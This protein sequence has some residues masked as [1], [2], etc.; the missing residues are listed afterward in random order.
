MK[1]ITEHF[2]NRALKKKRIR[3]NDK[4]VFTRGIKSIGIVAPSQQELKETVAVIKSH[5]DQNIQVN[6][7]FY[8]E[9]T[10]EEEAFSYRD[11]SLF[12]KPKEKI[13]K[14]LSKKP[15]VLIA[16]S[17]KLNSF[18]LYV[19]YLNPEPYSLGFYTED[20]KEYLDL[21]LT[22]ES[23]ETTENMEHL[24]KYLKQVI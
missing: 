24:M 1:W 5:F 7:I 11:F 17:G 2:I 23:A 3:R 19:L 4:P 10:Q 9:T 21:M 15:Q 20:I 18:S 13:N 12:G 14:F 22:N 8:S 16:T 6:G